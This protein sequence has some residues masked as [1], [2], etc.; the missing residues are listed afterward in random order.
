M[1]GAGLLDWVAKVFSSRGL[2]VAQRKWYKI[3][4]S[5]LSCIPVWFVIWNLYLWFVICILGWFEG[6]RLHFIL[7][8]W[9]I[10]QAGAL[11]LWACEEGWVQ[12]SMDI[13]YFCLFF[14]VIDNTK[15]CRV[16][17]EFLDTKSPR[18]APIMDGRYLAKLQT[19]DFKLAYDNYS[20][21]VAFM[22]K[23]LRHLEPRSRRNGFAKLPVW[24]RRGRRDEAGRRMRLSV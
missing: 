17:S 7:Y 24:W 4:S 20:E 13:D 14:H 5:R 12:V 1:I 21:L 23:Y 6:C 22:D 19:W 9:F 18:S 10:F 2:Q 15:G 3:V 11:A 16:A 8:L